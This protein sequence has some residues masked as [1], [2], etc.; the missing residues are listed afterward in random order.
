MVVPETDEESPD[1]LYTDYDEIEDDEIESSATMKTATSLMS[2]HANAYSLGDRL[3]RLP[4]TLP[5][6]S[7]G[8]A[9]GELLGVVLKANISKRS[10]AIARLV[11]FVIGPTGGKGTYQELAD[12]L[13]DSCDLA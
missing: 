1:A 6:I 9:K 8:M 3:A 10:A 2:I 5:Q 4:F 7:K 11:N 13:W 12:E